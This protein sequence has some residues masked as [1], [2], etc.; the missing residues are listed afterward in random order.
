MAERIRGRRLQA[1]NRLFLSMHPLCVVCEDEGRTRAAN[2]VDHIVP[3]FNG[4]AD[5]ETNLQGL[6]E[7]CHKAKTRADLGQGTKGADVTGAPT[8]PLHPWNR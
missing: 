6:C 4:G 8:D 2:E 3:L 1:R 7:D 5:D